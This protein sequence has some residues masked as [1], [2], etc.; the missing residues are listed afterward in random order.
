VSRSGSDRRRD[1]WKSGRSRAG[2]S[3]IEVLLVLTLLGAVFS[4]AIWLFIQN[5]RFYDRSD[6]TIGARENLRATI[7]LLAAEV[8]QASPADFL[9]AASDSLAIRFNLSR[10]IVC[11]ST[12][13][14]EV[15]LVVFDTVRA[16][17][18]P[19]AFRGTAV[20]DPY[21][22]SFTFLDGWRPSVIGKGSGPRAACEAR[23]SSAD[24]PS[25]R[26][27]ALRGWRSRYGKL[28][29]AGSFV[30]IY[31]RLS[32][33]LGTSSFEPGLGVWRN[34]QELASP[35][36]EGSSFSY[37]LEGGAEQSAVPVE[38]LGRIRAVRVRLEATGRSGGTR[39]QPPVRL[40]AEH[41]VFLRN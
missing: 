8:R 36:A 41:L 32:Y 21:D 2:F 10:A 16:A 17:N 40:P 34:G 1:T 13:L 22:S 29:R 5:S 7:D 38:A 30:R 37:V 6:E 4:A 23:G 25:S 11:D 33:R 31:G 35:F 12:G 19:S 15:A 14:D 39:F 26:F 24:L 27:R 9:A 28:P 18:V 3:L 20:S